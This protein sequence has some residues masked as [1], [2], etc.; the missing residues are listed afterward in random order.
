MYASKFVGSAVF[1]R[2]PLG[3][4][5]HH[6]LVSQRAWRM[7]HPHACPFSGRGHWLVPK[8]SSASGTVET[9]RDACV[10]SLRRRVKHMGLYCCRVAITAVQ[11]HFKCITGLGLQTHEILCKQQEAGYM[12]SALPSGSMCVSA[13]FP[14][15]VL[16][17]TRMLLAHHMH[18]AVQ[19]AWVPVACNSVIALQVL[20]VR[21]P[22]FSAGHPAS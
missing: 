16:L 14:Q 11:H 1:V 18:A 21:P 5:L 20:L 15:Q 17:L 3:M 8:G 7:A 19:E 6:T 4:P 22:F 10:G 9:A 13:S 2:Q 12:T